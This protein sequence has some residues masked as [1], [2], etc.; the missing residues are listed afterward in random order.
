MI[1]H[2]WISLAWYHYLNLLLDMTFEREIILWKVNLSFFGMFV[3]KKYFDV[4]ADAF[5]T[6]FHKQEIETSGNR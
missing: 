2:F 6:T 5:N 4:F 1:F 3:G